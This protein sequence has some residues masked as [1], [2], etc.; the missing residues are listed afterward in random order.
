MNS[1]TLNVDDTNEVEIVIARRVDASQ[2]WEVLQ[3][4]RV[5]VLLVCYI[6]ERTHNC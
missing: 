5:R 3:C 1:T 4:Q 2:A 6:T